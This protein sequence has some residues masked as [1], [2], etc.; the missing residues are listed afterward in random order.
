MRDIGAQPVTDI[1]QGYQQDRPLSD[2]D[3]EYRGYD[4]PGN[5]RPGLPAH[6]AYIEKIAGQINAGL[7]SRESVENLAR[8]NPRVS[9]ILKAAYSGYLSNQSK[10][11]EVSGIV[12]KYIS[13]GSP[14]TT[15]DVGPPT[16]EGQYGLRE[17][18]AI[19]AKRDYQGAVDAL[20]QKP[21]YLEYAEKYQKLGGLD[22]TTGKGLYGGIRTGI[23]PGTNKLIEYAVDEA[24]GQTKEVGTGRVLTR[25]KD[26]EPTIGVTNMPVLGGGIQ[27]FPNRGGIGEP[28]PSAPTGQTAMPTEGETKQYGQGINAQAMGSRLYELVNSGKVKV[29]PVEGRKLTAA[30][31]TGL[32]LTDEEAE[33]SSLEENYSNA[34]LQAMRGAQVG[35]QEQEMFNR[36]LPRRN[37]PK[38]VFLQNVRTTLGNIERISAAA[39]RIRAVPKLPSASTQSEQKPAFSKEEIMKEIQRRRI[40]GKL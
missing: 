26:Y 32:T 11:S 19:P 17:I 38:A 1:E 23:I 24:T 16:Q 31:V 30:T 29:G 35:P 9:S 13:Q 28:L 10:Q 14:A 34:L 4:K 5:L 6:D 33:L 36:S 18:P 15:E 20:A 37:Q 22:K 40:E 7:V 39:S 12:G 2:V 27:S 25:G 3:A 8:L 21:A